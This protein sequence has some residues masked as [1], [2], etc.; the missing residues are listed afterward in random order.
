MKADNELVEDG[1]TPGLD[2]ATD[3][4]LKDGTRKSIHVSV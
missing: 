1:K 2:A 4:F 3:Y